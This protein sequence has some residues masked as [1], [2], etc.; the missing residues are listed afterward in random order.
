LFTAKIWFQSLLFDIIV[1]TSF[2]LKP[3]K[4]GIEC[5]MLRMLALLLWMCDASYV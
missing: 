2:V 4:T 5:V 3:Q 1:R